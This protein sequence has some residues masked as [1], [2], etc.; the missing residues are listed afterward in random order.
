MNCSNED[1]IRNISLNLTKSYKLCGPYLGNIVVW[2]LTVY[3]SLTIIGV[4]ANLLLLFAIH[5]DPLKCFRN[6]TT[7]FIVNVAITNVLNILYY[8]QEV[9]VSRTLCVPGAWTKINLAFGSFVHFLTFPSVTALALERYVS[10]ARPLWHKVN[11]TSRLCYIWIAVVWVVCFILT[12]ISTTLHLNDNVF[13]VAGIFSG[14]PCIFYLSTVLIYLLAYI[15]IRK[16][17][18]S[19]IAENLKSETEKRMLKIRLKN[20]KRFI[21]TILLVNL[22]LIFGIIP[23]IVGTLSKLLAYNGMI[24]TSATEMLFNVINILLFISMAINP[25]LYIWR[26]PKYRKTFL[27]LYCNKI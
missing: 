9:L 4:A 16:Q 20:Q 17:K 27:V 24:S 15:S 25:F 7:Y 18:L 13:V 6:P 23:L 10:I 11:V 22:V 1:A 12:G 19:F 2:D 14:F 26:L 5:K 3:L 8:A 21:T